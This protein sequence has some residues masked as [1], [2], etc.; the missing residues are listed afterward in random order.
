M[1]PALLRVREG[2]ADQN[3]IYNPQVKFQKVAILPNTKEVFANPIDRNESKTFSQQMLVVL[4][5]KGFSKANLAKQLHISVST[6]N[7]IARGAI[8]QPANKTFTKLLRLY[9]T[10]L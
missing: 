9:C 3:E 2:T 5:Q 1:S 10:T 6:L 4:L 8:I 7:R